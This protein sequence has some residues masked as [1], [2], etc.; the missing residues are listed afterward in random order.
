M[1]RPFLRLSGPHHTRGFTLIELMVAMALSLLLLG[2]TFSLFQQLNNASDLVSTMADV[3]ENL[4]V[5]VNT[6]ARDLSTAGSEIPQGGIPIPTGGT[7]T[8]INRPGPPGKG[9]TFPPLPLTTIPVITPGDALGPAQGTIT[10]DIVTIISVNELSQLDEY[11][12]TAVSN[13]LTSASVTVNTATCGWGSPASACPVGFTAAN[14][15]V[16][17][18]QLIMLTNVNGSCLLTATAVS[19][20]TG[21][22]TFANGNPYD[23][24]GVNQFNG[25]TS[26]TIVQLKTGGAYPSTTAYAINMVTYYLDTSIPNHQLM[27]V[28][29][30]Q[31]QAGTPQVMARGINVL[32]FAYSLSPPAS[33]TDPDGWATTD[34]TSTPP[35]TTYAPNTIRKVCLWII[36]TADHP[37]PGT[38]QVYT[39]EIATS[40]TIQNLAY[41]NKY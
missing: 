2:L 21:V 4:R 33:P 27:R 38:K 39:K 29:P 3:N 17:P 25:P 11:T 22:I 13:T 30:Q 31:F 24:L 15:Q 14:S 1:S 41:Y 34:S 20:T 6:V 40:L 18:G 36:A 8:L 5:A 19:L 10:T 26:G 9:L 23:V 7:A 32:Q 28:T 37:N 16:T 35:W 12:L